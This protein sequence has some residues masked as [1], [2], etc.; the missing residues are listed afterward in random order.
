MRPLSIG[1]MDQ[2][3][4]EWYRGP[5]WETERVIL[6]RLVEGAKEDRGAV[7]YLDKRLRLLHESHK[8][9][10]WGMKER[11]TGLA[12]Q[13]DRLLAENKVAAAKAEYTLKAVRRAQELLRDVN[14]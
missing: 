9:E 5:L 6:E 3:L 7:G 13:A 8:T 4:K 11:I 2:V 10:V 1:E 14:P 12:E